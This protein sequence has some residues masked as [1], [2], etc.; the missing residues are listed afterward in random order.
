MYTHP[1]PHLQ[2]SSKPLADIKATDMLQF[3][4]TDGTEEQRLC[5]RLLDSGALVHGA[6]E[7]VAVR[8]PKQVTQL[9]G[10]H[11]YSRA[12]ETVREVNSE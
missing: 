7:V 6:L 9:M 8:Q 11:L 3:P 5:G 2:Q 1:I 10:H 12:G 4:E